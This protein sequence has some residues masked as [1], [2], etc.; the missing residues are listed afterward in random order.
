LG[1]GRRGKVTPLVLILWMVWRREVLE[2]E[3]RDWEELWKGL[4]LELDGFVKSTS[5]T[6]CAV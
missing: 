2:R 3:N 1:R 6:L 5:E 4:M